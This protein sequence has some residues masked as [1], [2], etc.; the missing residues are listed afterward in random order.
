M[1]VPACQTQGH[2]LLA[3]EL[4][5]DAPIVVLTPHPDDESLGCGALLAAAFA[6]NGARVICLTDGSRSHPRSTAWPSHRLAQKRQEELSEAVRRL[7]GEDQDITWLGYPDGQLA[8]QD[9][10]VIAVRIG[11]ICQGLNAQR[12]FST[13][14]LDEHADH[15]AAAQI[16]R[17]VCHLC[18]SLELFYY[19]VWSRYA[20]PSF[21]SANHGCRILSVTTEAHRAAKARAIDAHAS[22]LG[23]TVE[24][25][26]EGFSLDPAMV[27][28]FTMQDEIYFKV[29]SCA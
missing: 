14:P 15:K 24:D 1:N 16:A 22:Q 8:A 26:P 4:A 27:R 10:Q 25:D 5:G 7:G 12:L 17:R 13:S 29:P 9:A 21:R 3:G 28:L 2:A 11:R 19:P 23:R 18:P 20:D 6:Q